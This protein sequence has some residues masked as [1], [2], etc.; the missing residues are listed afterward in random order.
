MK[1]H[2]VIYV[3][4][5][6]DPRYGKQGWALRLWSV[7]GVYAH[8]FPLIWGDGELFEPKFKRLIN[9]IDEVYD[10]GHIVSLVGVSAGA[11]AVV[12]AYAQRKDKINGVVCICGKLNNPQT[13][14]PHIFIKNPAFKGSMEKLP[15]SLRKLSSAK[16]RRILSIHPLSDH[17]VPPADTIIPGAQEKRV[18]SMGHVFTIATQI[19]LG[20]PAFISYLKRLAKI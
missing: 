13:M 8:Y 4:G 2:H 20:A 1:Q 10:Q 9:K 3:P 14:Y 17:S 16:R 11:S 6:G 19:T 18:I 15:S 12:N 7:Y 5:L